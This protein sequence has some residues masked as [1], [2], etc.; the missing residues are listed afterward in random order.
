MSVLRLLHFCQFLVA[1]AVLQGCASTYL[2][3]TNPPGANVY[4][5]DPT[6][7]KRFLIGATP[8]SYSKG[9][10]PTDAAFMV[11]VEK[12]GFLPQD[13]PMAP[14][15]ESRT[16]VSVNLKADTTTVARNNKEL[17]EAVN[18]LFRAQ[19]LIYRKQYQ[20]AIIELD[21]ILKDKPDLTQ[22]QVMKGT[23]YYLLNE[24]PSAINAWKEAMKLDPN[25]EELSKFLADNSIALK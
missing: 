2:I 20:A 1:A 9:A 17:N 23:A 25:N 15:N 11:T 6:T 21:K 16:I 5:N 8:L 12:E 4:F 18:Y 14:T 19:Q 22:A 10:L 7:Q 3:S 13:V 24:L